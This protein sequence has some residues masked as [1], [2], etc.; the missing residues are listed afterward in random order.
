MRL[1][2]EILQHIFRLASLQAKDVSRSPTC[3]LIA[4]GDIWSL[5]EPVPTKVATLASVCRRWRS[6]ALAD[7]TL[8]NTISDRQDRR[9]LVVSQG[10]RNAALELRLVAS[11]SCELRALLQSDGHRVRAIDWDKANVRLEDLAL[12]ATPSCRLEKL[13][14]SMNRHLTYVDTDVLTTWITPQAPSLRHLTLRDCGSVSGCMFPR[15]TGLHLDACTSASD[16]DDL[17]GLLARAP[18]LTDLVLSRLQLGVVYGTPTL[19]PLPNLRRLVFTDTARG[20]V[21]SLLARVALP[22]TASIRIHAFEPSG[23]NEALDIEWISA[24]AKTPALSNATEIYVEEKSDIF[25]AGPAAAVCFVQEN[26][27]QPLAQRRA[28]A[29]APAWDARAVLPHVLAL[30]PV[31]KV[32][33]LSEAG[34]AG[35]SSLPPSVDTVVVLDT[36]LTTLLGILDNKRLAPASEDEGV[37]GQSGPLTV[38]VLMTRF[39]SA[40]V[41]LGKIAQRADSRDLHVAIGCLPSY[42]GDRARPAGFDDAFASLKFVAHE[43]LPTVALPD[44]C[45]ARAHSLWPNWV[46]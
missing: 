22:A 18:N 45:M 33:L 39:M 20:C 26:K 35:V 8:W 19:V 36:E 42:L 23:A 41:V 4:T 44:V 15:L 1:P 21:G 27:A 5:V 12:L 28:S 13:V 40:K 24:L 31:R 14:L 32:W 43:T 2:P 7:S 25:V 38:Q 29:E 11:P 10:S 9:P 37:A 16:C 17:L 6:V 30:A 3:T 46:E 34:I